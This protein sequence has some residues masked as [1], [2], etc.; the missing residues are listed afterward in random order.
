MTEERASNQELQFL[1]SLTQVPHRNIDADLADYMK[2]VAENPSLAAKGLVWL[3]RTSE[4]RD[5]R[6]AAAQAL[7]QSTA[8]YPIIREAGRAAML[9]DDVYLIVNGFDQDGHAIIGGLDKGLE[10]HM[11]IKVILRVFDSKISPKPTRFVTNLGRDWLRMLEGDFKRWEGVEIRNR[12]DMSRLYTLLRHR[13]T[14]DRIYQVLYGDEP[15]E[16]SIRAMVKR[17]DALAR[18]GDMAGAARLALS[19]E[20][21]GVTMQIMSA[22]FPA[23]SQYGI[24]AK[25][26]V[27]TPNEARNAIAEVERSGILEIP[28]VREAFE[29]KVSKATRNI[30]S[31]TRRKSSQTQDVRLQA[32]V[33]K[34]IQAGIDRGGKIQRRMMI[35]GDISPSMER[36]IP[37]MVQIVARIAAESECEPTVIFFSSRAE[38]EYIPDYSLRALERRFGMKSTSGG[39]AM[40]SVYKL[41]ASHWGE[42]DTIVF[43]TDCEELHSPRFATVIPDDGNPEIFVVRMWQRNRGGLPEKV[44]GPP[45]WDKF[46]PGLDRKAQ[47]TIL[48]VD[49]YFTRDSNYYVLDQLAALLRGER[50]KTLFEQIYDTFLPYRLEARS[51]I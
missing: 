34:A 26:A 29:G 44:T 9:G 38:I 12:E 25:I 51:L 7:L 47:V 13:P 23:S 42:Y 50:A 39:T 3:I 17:I 6:E 24:I 2:F 30:A 49:E 31:A 1:R 11:I 21:S 10:P 4:I 22:I 48:D 5:L 8:E 20:A 32:A 28:E 27:M 40:G 43:V 16:G 41:M 45:S 15:P 46:T 33:D 35:C 36:T 19:D 37:A 14:E 18:D